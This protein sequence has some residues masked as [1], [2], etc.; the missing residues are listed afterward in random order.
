MAAQLDIGDYLPS[1]FTFPCL[2][3]SIKVTIIRLR[4][5]LLIVCVARSLSGSEEVKQDEESQ[6]GAE[7]ISDV[8]MKQTRTGEGAKT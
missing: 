3:Q 7:R 1:S 6:N 8:K 2:A 4:S 5:I